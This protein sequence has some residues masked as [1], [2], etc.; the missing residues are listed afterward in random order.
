MNTTSISSN[1]KPKQQ[2]RMKRSFILRN[3]WLKYAGGIAHTAYENSED[4]CVY[5]Q[6]VEYLLNPPSGNPSKFINKRRTSEMALFAFFQEKIN[7]L[8]LNDEYPDFAIDSGVSSQLIAMLCDHLKRNMYAFDESQ[9][10]FHTITR[11]TSKNYSPIVYYKLHGHCYLIDDVSMIKSVATIN[12]MK[13]NKIIT[14]TLTDAVKTEIKMDVFHL[15][16]YIVSE[17]K[18]MVE[19]IYLLNQSNFD[20]EIIDFISL[21]KNVP[22]TKSCKS[23][24]V[25]IKFEVGMVIKKEN[26]KYVIICIDST[27]GENYDY[28]QIKNVANNCDITYINDGIG[29]L[30]LSILEKG[31]KSC[32]E[33][34]APVQRTSF[35][36]SCGNKCA[37]CSLPCDAFEIDHIIPLAGGGSNDCSNLQILC[38]KCHKEK[39]IHENKSG[40]YKEKVNES[41]VFNKYVLDNIINESEWK[42]WAFIEK[43]PHEASLLKG[44]FLTHKYDMVKC[45]KNIAYHSKYEF[46]VYS[47]M[48]IPTTF[49][50]T[51]QCG[52]YYINSDK[53]FPFRGCGWYCEPI[54]AYGLSQDIIKLTDIK[55]EFVPS[56]KLPANHF[57]KPID[58]LLDA[59]KCEP[60]LLKYCINSL[61]GLLGR[62]KRNS[63][64]IRFSLCKHEA[65]GWWGDKDPKCNVFIKNI[66]LNNGEILYEGIFSEDV[67]VE[68]INYCLYKQIVEMEAVELHK[69]ES[70]ICKN[71][72]VPLDRNTDAIRYAR[73]DPI[74]L[75]EYW[76]EEKTILKYQKELA[77]P[78][79]CEVFGGFCRKQELD[80]SIFDLNWNIQD[81]YLGCAED[82]ACRV[83]DTNMSMHIDGYAGTGKTFLVNN[84]IRELKQREKNY[85]AFSPTNKG[86]RLIG[87]NTIHSI[88][89]KFK[90][91]RKALFAK[92]EKVE[93]IFIDEVSMMI[94]DF[95]QL[96]VLIKRSFPSIKFIIAGDFGQLP[97]VRDNW[98]GDYENSPAMHSLCDGQRIKLSKC[99]RSD[100]KL[101]DLCRSVETI[102]ITQFKPTEDTYLNL[103]YTHDTRIKIN[104]QC[105][106]RYLGSNTGVAIPKDKK[107][108]KTQNVRLSKGM[109]II[110]HTTNKQM[111]ILNSQ[112]FEIIDINSQSFTIINDDVPVK[113]PNI[114]FH[115]HFYLGFC[116]TI[117]ASQGETYS[118]KYTI[119]DW[120]F[121]R[122]CE[123]AKYV[124]MSR[125]TN[126][127][128]IQI[129]Q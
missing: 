118:S 9:R 106:K 92:M 111:N 91:N 109:P 123:K 29:S 60:S 103:A 105:M 34:L 90:S 33:Y 42:S 50:G 56:V 112:T 5:A 94:K 57:Q 27:H 127:S 37:V 58:I 19:G 121:T 12:A 73:K 81:D 101:F 83:V 100:R 116:I 125:G 71:G 80:L 117:H 99:R 8:H 54:V 66:E 82:E 30:I 108:P 89:Y 55:L 120:K 45:R 10:M 107:N 38:N 59:F 65:A 69:L 3:D 129:A 7:E 70:I 74:E 44:D 84:I 52:M 36:E 62:T 1:I 86:A 75:I 14:N 13:G 68:A 113:I 61:I 78:L 128:N 67:D 95:Y 85:L 53:T 39:T 64:K 122:F 51:V 119:H 17:S 43:A 97:P 18:E 15:E 35:I 102:D 98:T 126:I 63:T 2:Q 40:A 11:N 41:S 16:K 32:R 77:K 26:K 93:Y 115:K 76:D 31:G 28:E 21:F 88:Y 46:P 114:N 49:S 47:V 104:N 20:D 110:A 96:F 6:L 25:E 24:V 87:G 23:N 48:D 72:G 4:K 22:M 79:S 124:A